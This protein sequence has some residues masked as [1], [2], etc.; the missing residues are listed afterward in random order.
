MRVETFAV[1]SLAE[2]AIPSRAGTWNLL[3]REIDIDWPPTGLRPVS[4]T[5]SALDLFSLTSFP[6]LGASDRFVLYGT[7]S[8]AA[9][10]LS[11]SAARGLLPADIGLLLHGG[12][13]SWIFPRDPLTPS[14]LSE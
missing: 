11:R 8:Q 5:T 7:G 2:Q 9:A 14:N 1:P 3:I 13:W 4:A 6:L 12:G 10:A